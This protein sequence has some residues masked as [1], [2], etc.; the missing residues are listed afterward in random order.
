MQRDTNA[1][2]FEL[3]RK[4]IVGKLTTLIGV[5]DGRSSPMGDGF[6]LSIHAKLHIHGAGKVPSQHFATVPINHGAQ[7]HPAFVH[8]HVSDVY[9]P[10]LIGVGHRLVPQQIGIDL[11]LG[12]ASTDA[13]FAVQ[14]R[15]T[16]ALHQGAYCGG[17]RNVL[18]IAAVP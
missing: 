9:D 14:R 18:G 15:N 1:L 10:D 16:H 2:A 17:P 5:E 6:L 7:V 12:M 11:M 3:R 13:G 8:M 4:G